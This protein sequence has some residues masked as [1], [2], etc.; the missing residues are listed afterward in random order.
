[1]VTT[2]QTVLPVRLTTVIRRLPAGAVEGGLCVLSAD[3]PALAETEADAV[4]EA[5]GEALRLGEADG[6]GEGCEVLHAPEDGRA[7]AW[8]RSAGWPPPIPDS[9]HAP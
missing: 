4:G 8:G 3:A 6:D 2:A 5:E 1:L 9:D 7:A